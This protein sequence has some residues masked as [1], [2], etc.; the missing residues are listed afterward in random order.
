VP[1]RTRPVLVVE[2]SPEDFE[3]TR[4]SLQRSGFPH[5]LVHVGDGDA[6]L[7]Y[8][9]HRGSFSRADRSPRPRLILLD[10]NLPGTDGRQV[11]ASIKADDDLRRIPVVVFT[12]SRDE[13]DIEACYRAGANSYV[14]KPVDLPEFRRALDS[15][16]SYWFDT[17]VLPAAD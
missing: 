7:D 5:P 2:D 1:E 8:L 15:L 13:R 17:V 9:F 3:A 16:R 10:L 4:R 12:T 6:A 11:L 14:Q